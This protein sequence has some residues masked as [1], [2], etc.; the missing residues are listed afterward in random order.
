MIAGSWYRLTD[1]RSV[2]FLNGLNIVYDNP[3]PTDPNFNPR[4]IYEGETEVLL[5]QAIT[6][7]E[8]SP[9]GYSET[10]SNDII[11]YL[12]YTNK[13]GLSNELGNGEGVKTE[14]S[15]WLIL[16]NLTNL[17]QLN[18]LDYT[19]FYSALGNR[20]GNYVVGEEMIMKSTVS[21]NF[22]KIIFTSWTQGGQGGGFSYDRQLI[23]LAMDE[24]VISFTKTNYG[25]EV[26]IIEAGV[27]E[28]TRGNNG[29]IYNSAVEANSNGENP[30]NTEWASSIIII[31]GFDLQW[32]G[33]N[34]Y[35]NMPTDIPV[36]FGQGLYLFCEFDGGSYRQE[37][38][39]FPT[40]P[41][42]SLPF[43]SYT[44]DDPDF[45]NLKALSRIKIENNGMKVI[46][47]DLTETDYLNYDADTLFV[48]YLTPLG[49]AY[50]TIVRRQDTLINIDVPF[51]FRGIKYRRF[52]VDILGN[53]NSISYNATGTTAT[54]GTYLVTSYN[55]VTSNGEDASFRIKVLSGSVSSVEIVNRGRFYLN[56]DTFT[57]DG[58]SIGGTSITDDI[59]ITVTDIN[60]NVG[61]YGIGDNFLGQGTTGNYKDFKVFA[62]NGFEVSNIKWI[63][64]SI[65]ESPSDN[66]VFLEDV[67]NVTI[68]VGCS[69]NTIG[70][71][72][73]ITIGEDFSFN[74]IGNSF[75][76]NTIGNYFNGN[77]VGNNFG[78]NTVS[79]N[80]Q[81]NTLG[82]GFYGNTVGNSFNSNTVGDSFYDNTVGNN[83]NSNT[84][85]NNFENNTVGNNFQSN[86]VDNNFENNTVGNNFQ[87]NTLGNL[88]NN[89]TIGNRFNENT[90]GNTF[91]NNQILEN[92][93]LNIIGDN[94]DSNIIGENFEKNAI[95]EYF[96]YNTIRGSFFYNEIS[97]DFESNTIGI[98]FE[99]NTI[100]YNFDSNTIGND[101]NDNTIGHSF[102]SNT[103]GN[104]SEQNTIGDSFS[105]NTIG[106]R[107]ENNSIGNDFYS[108]KIAD[109]FV[110]NTVG[111]NFQRNQ[112]DYPLISKDFSS[113]THVYA[114]YN[115]TIFRASN[116]IEYL[117]YFD[118]TTVQYTSVNS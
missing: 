65:S 26:D 30:A 109:F 40:K 75:S 71:C 11:Q 19:T 64:S 52:E 118:G 99:D 41:H 18:T 78:N 56:N 116:I 94:F 29:P 88:F 101:F 79:N 21:G 6:E 50:G 80:F 115:C 54:D 47:L 81:S 72:D 107:F 58:T 110:S 117:S 95:D 66:V 63:G 105:S 90:I 53:I 103:I 37:G 24:P 67:Q 27:L 77:I 16:D 111:N 113:A 28:I 46:L 17:S 104:E 84:V 44:S 8:I 98:G 112:I 36:Y 74:T 35:F 7:S 83:F 14:N 70:A 85:D 10:F 39:Y 32:D 13:I 12:P 31:S 38:A 60:S 34:V 82:N 102:S 73:N 33:T 49:D 92:F 62:E 4:E 20:I 108:N 61:Y 55:S 45:N 106:N 25:S 57:I 100:D 91:N 48:T 59:L 9:I 76:N 15:P 114:D 93:Y 87:S 1:Y 86:T 43:I 23:T 22:Y 51:D 2:N 3:I 97:Y 96:R 89:N 69:N 42:T 5:L 68:G